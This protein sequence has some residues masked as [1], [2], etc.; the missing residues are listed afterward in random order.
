MHD[1]QSDSSEEV[2]DSQKLFATML[3]ESKSVKM[4]I[5]SGATC[6]IVPQ[7]LVPTTTSIVENRKELVSYCKN[8]L[9]AI[10]VANIS[11]RNAKNNKKYRAEFVIVDG[12][13]TPIIGA[14]A[15]QKMDLIVVQR[16]N[17]LEVTSKTTPSSREEVLAEYHDVFE[18]LGKMEGKLNL[19]K[20]PSAQPVVMPPRRVPVSRK[21]KLKD[22]LKRL[23]GLGVI[24]KQDK[25]TDWVSSLVVF[26]KTD[27]R[28][29][30]Y[31]EPL[32]LNK[33]LKR[34]HYPLPVIE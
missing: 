23:E 13:Y 9:K 22:E 4:Q 26:E 19:E 34:S 28:V 32:H 18:N 11:F 14:S 33:V 15:A 1:L 27:G 29:R 17:I 20:D 30:V 21:D 3:I 16:H 24:A 8:K 6:N 2:R 7:K 25:P 12:D 10:G 31:I 5:D